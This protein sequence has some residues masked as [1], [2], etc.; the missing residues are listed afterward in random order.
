VAAPMS[1]H[2][3]CH[4]TDRGGRCSVTSAYRLRAEIVMSG[5]KSLVLITVEDMRTG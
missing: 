3:A 4:S 2:V 1:S 5:T